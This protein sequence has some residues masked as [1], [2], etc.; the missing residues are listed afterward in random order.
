MTLSNIVDQFSQV[1]AAVSSA[2]GQTVHFRHGHMVEVAGIVQQMVKD[3]DIDKRYPIIALQHDFEQDPV[4]FKG[5]ELKGLKLY[6]ITLSRPDYIAEQ[7]KELIFKPILYPIRDL[8]IE[9]IARSGYFEQQ[10]EEEVLDVITLTDRY[11]WGS[12]TVMGNTANIFSDWVDCIEIDIDGLISYG[13]VCGT[14]VTYPRLV[15]VLTDTENHPAPV[16]LKVFFNFDTAIDEGTVFSDYIKIKKTG[17]EAYP[18]SILISDD[19]KT[20]IAHYPEDDIVNGDQLTCD[21]TGGV[22]YTVEGIELKPVKDF[23]VQNNVQL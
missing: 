15:N 14:A 8:F 13:V 23:Y 20:I 1:V 4:S 9:K 5:I 16:G 18:D 22:I 21:I 17:Y 10:S 3:P 11:Y 7:R 12:S 19:D 2:Y 6:I